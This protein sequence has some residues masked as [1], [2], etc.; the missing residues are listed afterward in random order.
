MSVING[1]AAAPRHEQLESL[2]REVD[3]LADENQ[4]ITACFIG[5]EQRASDL[6]KLL[7]ALRCLHEATDRAQ[8]L[9]AL[10]EVVVNVLGSEA[11]AICTVDGAGELV[12]ERSLGVEE[13]RLAGVR[14]GEA[15]S[16]A[17]ACVPIVRGRSVVGAIVIFGLLEHKAE[18]EPLDLELLAM[19]SVHAGAAL[20]SAA[21]PGPRQAL[22]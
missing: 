11:M 7:L 14:L 19:L 8:L 15:P 5:E 9:G 3:R 12:V 2:Q 18:L 22:A 13:G 21:W 1:H 20:A 16:D 10:E 4:R 17:L 6:M